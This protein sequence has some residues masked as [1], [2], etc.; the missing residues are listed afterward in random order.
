L[1]ASKVAFR[2]VVREGQFSDLSAAA[3]TSVYA[4]LDAQRGWILETPIAR[5]RRSCV[6]RCVAVIGTDWDEILT[7]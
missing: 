5:H 1:A 7:T 3:I 2:C 6:A 4:M